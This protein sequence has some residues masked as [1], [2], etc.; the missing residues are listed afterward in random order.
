MWNWYD[1][2]TIV[3]KNKEYKVAAVAPLQYK[4]KVDLISMCELQLR[5]YRFDCFPFFVLL[6]FVFEISGISVVSHLN[7]SKDDG[8]FGASL[9]TVIDFKKKQLSSC[10][11][12]HWIIIES[13]FYIGKE[14]KPSSM[15][16]IW[17]AKN[18]E[19][20]FIDFLEWKVT[21]HEICWCCKTGDFVCISM[22]MNTKAERINSIKWHKKN[23]LKMIFLMAQESDSAA[24]IQCLDLITWCVISA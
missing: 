24:A 23:I 9:N 6:H 21:Q 12:V 14:L 8:L 20:T 1:Y 22:R 2:Y 15:E 4:W 10:W 13:C 17:V 11:I 16:S 5:F 3:V 19:E 7:K 18:F